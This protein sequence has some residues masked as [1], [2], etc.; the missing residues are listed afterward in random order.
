[1]AWNV[2]VGSALR[3]EVKRKILESGAFTQIAE[4]TFNQYTTKMVKRLLKAYL[5]DQSS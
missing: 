4:H 1:M 3:E 5:E 2:S